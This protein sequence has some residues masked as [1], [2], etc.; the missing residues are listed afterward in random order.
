MQHTADKVF[1][2]R[3]GG[4][5]SHSKMRIQLILL[6]NIILLLSSLNPALAW[7]DETHMAIAK[8]A[9][10]SKWY[11]AAGADIAKIKAGNKEATN[12]WFDN[13]DGVEI[14]PKLV[15]EQAARYDKAD[16]DEG[17]LY[18][19]IIQSLRNYLKDTKGGKY[20]EYHMAFC[21]HYIGDLSQP[22]HNGPA[23]PRDQAYLTYHST[24]DGIVEA[25]ALNNIGLIQKKSYTITIRNGDDLAREIAVIANSSHQ[26]YLRLLSENKRDMSKDEAYEQLAKSVSLLRAVLEYA[27]QK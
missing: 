6:A 9:G 17:H 2:Q 11:N 18:G 7:H 25:E 5:L 21:A 19:A 26:L 10:Y 4:L 15:L 20:A 14:T 12:H 23:E 27:A 13:N 8:A 22:L 24:N 16:D 1:S 3:E